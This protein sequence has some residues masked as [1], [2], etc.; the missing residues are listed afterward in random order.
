MV[1]SRSRAKISKL[2][3]GQSVEDTA[4]RL[5]ALEMFS[6]HCDTHQSHSQK[7][8]EEKKNQKEFP[9]KQSLCKM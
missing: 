2:A 4:S 5:S 9:E 6:V 8:G 7:E 1:R 3:F